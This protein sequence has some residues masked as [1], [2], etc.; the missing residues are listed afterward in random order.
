MEIGKGKTLCGF[1]KK[2]DRSKT[3]CHI[4]SPETLEKAKEVL[5]GAN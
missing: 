5:G 2:T 1:V 4:E 3:A